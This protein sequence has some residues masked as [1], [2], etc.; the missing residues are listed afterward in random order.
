MWQDSDLQEKWVK[1]VRITHWS[2]ISTLISFCL[3]NT[4]AN[5]KKKSHR[6][7]LNSV[8]AHDFFI[9][10]FRINGIKQYI[11]TVH[12]RTF[13]GQHERINLT[14]I[15]KL[16]GRIDKWWLLNPLPLS[17]L[18]VCVCAHHSA[19]CPSLRRYVDAMHLW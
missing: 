1:I 10:R 2:R 18:C 5:E 17:M 12:L 11:N 3:F 15:W 13:E 14:F 6:F 7:K 8:L 4:A 9:R 19:H 16:D